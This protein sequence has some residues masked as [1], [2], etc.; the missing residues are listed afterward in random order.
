ML[1]GDSEVEVGGVVGSE[2]GKG[3]EVVEVMEVGVVTV[4]SG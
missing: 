4:E 1:D 3:M 2:L